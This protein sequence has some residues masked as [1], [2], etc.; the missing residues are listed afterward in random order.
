[1]QPENNKF[2]EFSRYAGEEKL[3]LYQPKRHVLRM[4]L[5]IL[6]LLIAAAAAAGAILRPDLAAELR[7]RFFASTG[8]GRTREQSVV[9]SGGEAGDTAE[10]SGN[11]GSTAAAG[12][13]EADTAMAP[14]PETTAE[15]ELPFAPHCT[16]TTNPANQIAWTEIE[17]NGETLE[18][19]AS[20]TA[21][22]E[23]SFGYG[24]DYRQAAGIFTFRGNNFRDDPTYGN[25]FI[26]ENIKPME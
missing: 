13:T 17:V 9:S 2:E 7:D 11:G 16:E 22:S 23:I 25:T 5:L 21:P 14:E 1:M 3:S 4:T 18:N 6:L 19:T 20:Y 8:I 10:G 12:Q 15:T 24:E 26:K